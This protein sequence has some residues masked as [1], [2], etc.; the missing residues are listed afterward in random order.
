MV[1]FAC[2]AS[3]S[4]LDVDVDCSGY[5]GLIPT[6]HYDLN[7]IKKKFLFTNI[8]IG[9]SVKSNNSDFKLYTNICYCYCFIVTV[10]D[11]KK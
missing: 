4:P 9:R 11:K 3:D 7:K 6:Y 5:Y 8:I 1:V 2:V 10:T